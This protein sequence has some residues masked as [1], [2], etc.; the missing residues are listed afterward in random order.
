MTSWWVG[1]TR[2]EFAAASFVERARMAYDG[3]RPTIEH[4]L[5]DTRGSEDLRSFEEEEEEDTVGEVDES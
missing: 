4:E 1:K 3:N 5:E 2:E